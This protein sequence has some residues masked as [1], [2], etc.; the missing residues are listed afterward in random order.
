L[1]LLDNF[2]LDFINNF[3]KEIKLITW[4]VVDYLSNTHFYKYIT[5]LFH[6][7]K[8]DEIKDSSSKTTENRSMIGENKYETKRNESKT[9]EI[10]RENNSHTKISEWLKPQEKIIEFNE[11][12]NYNKYFII[13]GTIVVVCLAWYYSDE[14]RS[15]TIAILDWINSFRRGD[16]PG[17]NPPNYNQINN[18]NRTRE[19]LEALVQE[20]IKNKSESSTPEID[21]FF[22]V[23]GKG[24]TVRVMSPSLEDLNEKVQESWNKSPTSSTSSIETVKASTSKTIESI[25]ENSLFKDKLDEAM[26]WSSNWRK[27]INKD[28]LSKINFIDQI[29][30][31]DKEIDRVTASTLIDFLV[32][33]HSSYNSTVEKFNITKNELSGKDID[34]TKNVSFELRKW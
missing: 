9:S 6:G 23:N 5:N 30:N 2:A 20:R 10:I 8:I 34:I 17:D 19:R 27:I 11:E 21:Q 32:D 1:S 4:N 3:F 22:P 12:S 25:N 15:G 7:N 33:V 16:N 13:V 24:K 18:Q 28:D 31:S 26:F 29:L 14:I